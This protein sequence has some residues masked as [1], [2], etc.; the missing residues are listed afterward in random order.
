MPRVLYTSDKHTFLEI[1]CYE[2]ACSVFV[3]DNFLHHPEST[4]TCVD[5]FLPDDPTTPGVC[6]EIKKT[7]YENIGKSENK[8]KIRVVEAKSDDFFASNTD[9][10]S[11]IYIDGDHRYEQ[12]KKDITNAFQVLL[13]GGIIWCD[14]YSYCDGVKQA[15]H[16][17][18]LE[19]VDAIQIFHKNNQIAFQKI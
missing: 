2:G 3:S 9:L 6:E 1:G 7:F 11:F 16:E 12:V 4:L 5:P 14:D 18:I 15:I 13:K 17:F 8:E 10:F 19:N